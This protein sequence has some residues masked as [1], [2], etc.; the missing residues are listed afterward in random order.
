MCGAA[1]DQKL[2]QWLKWSELINISSMIIGI[3]KI[4]TVILSTAKNPVLGDNPVDASLRSEWRSNNEKWVL[5]DP[6][7]ILQIAQPFVK[8]GRA[9]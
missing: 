3:S 1:F 7:V 6:L 8:R 2:R 9:F 5:I 4:S